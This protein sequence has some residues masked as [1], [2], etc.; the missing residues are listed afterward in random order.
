M[1]RR[2]FLALV[3]ASTGAGIDALADSLADCA[4]RFARAYNEFFSDVGR[5]I[6]DNKRARR[7]S[8]LWRDLENCGE[9]PK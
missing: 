5:G 2:L 9:W 7:L 3:I 8:K 6:F 4:N 1:N